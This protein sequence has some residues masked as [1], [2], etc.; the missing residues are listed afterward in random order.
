[1]L[2]IPSIRIYRL[3]T[4]DRNVHANARL[5]SAPL[6]LWHTLYCQSGEWTQVITNHDF[7]DDIFI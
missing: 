3:K 6:V 7:F 1:M 4:N 5:H 2:G